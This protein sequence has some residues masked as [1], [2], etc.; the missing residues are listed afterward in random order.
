MRHLTPKFYFPRK[1]CAEIMIAN[2][3][4]DGKTLDNFIEMLYYKQ[5]SRDARAVRYECRRWHHSCNC[6]I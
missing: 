5:A 2:A 1:K 4:Y 3:E 6:R